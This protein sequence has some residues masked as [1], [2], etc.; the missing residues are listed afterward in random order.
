MIH[1]LAKR[2]QVSPTPIREALVALE[3]NGILDLV[4]NCGAIVRKVTAADVR[5]I[6]QVRRALECEGFAR[7]AA[8][9][10][11]PSSRS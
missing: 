6:C 4:P 10:N 5:E 2:Y 7:R 9:S 11:W 8:G 1:A 3:A